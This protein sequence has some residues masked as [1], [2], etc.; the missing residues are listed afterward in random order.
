M[1]SKNARFTVLTDRVI[2]MEYSSSGKFVDDATLAFVNRNLPV[3]SFTSAT[4]GSNLV[5]KTSYLTLTYVIGTKFSSSTLNITVKNASVNTYNFGD[6]DDGNLLGTIKSL[7]NIGVTPLNCTLNA[8]LRIHDETLHC[9]WGLVSKN[10]WTTVDDS[11]NWLL[12]QTSDWWTVQ[13]TDDEDTYFFGHGD[14]FTDALYDYNLIGGKIAMPP[15]ASNGIYWSRWYNM[16][17]RDVFD[18]V[19]DYSNRGIPLD[20]YI[21][22]M[23]WHTKQGWGGYSWDKH[24]FPVPQAVMKQLQARGLL[25]SGNLHDDDG[26]RSNEEQYLPF[27]KALG[28][29]CSQNQTI[30]FQ[31]TNETHALALEDVVLKPLEDQGFGNFWWIDWQQGGAQGGCQGLKQNPTIWL[32]RLRASDH[33]RRG[34]NQRGMVLGRWGGLGNHR[35]QVGFSGDVD[36]VDWQNLAYQPYFSMTASNVLFGF[37]SHDIVSAFRGNGGNYD[38]ELYTRWVQWGA[39]SSVMRSHDRGMAAGTC[40]QS[41]PPT[42]AIDKIWNTPTPYFDAMRS[43]LQERHRLLPYLYNAQRQ[44]YDTGISLMRPLYYTFA[45]EPNAYLADQNGNYPQYMLGDDM[46]VAPIVSQGYN[47]DTLARQKLWVPPGTWID[48]LTGNVVSVGTGGDTVTRAY[49][50]SEVPRFVRA[51]AIIPKIPLQL[52][53]TVGRAQQQ[54]SSLEFVLYLAPGVNFGST[55]VYEDDASTTA[56][57]AEGFYLTAVNF[58][59]SANSMTISVSAPGGGKGYPEFPKQRNYFFRYTGSPPSSV[60]MGSTTLAYSLS[61]GPNTWRFDGKTMQVVLETAMLDTSAGFSIAITAA[62]TSFE[63]AMYGI[64]G[65]LSRANLAKQVLDTS[66]STPGAQIVQNAK[67]SDTASSGVSFSYF[68]GVDMKTFTQQVLAFQSLYQQ[69]VSEILGLQPN[70]AYPDNALVQWWNEDRQD[71]CLCSH[72]SCNQI[73]QESGYTFVRIEGYVPSSSEPSTAQLFDFYSSSAQDNLATTNPV[74]PSSY[75]PA[76]FSNGSVYASH[77]AKSGTVPLKTFYSKT[78][79]DWLTV[80]SQEGL[81][82]AKANGYVEGDIVGYVYSSSPLSL[83]SSTTPPSQD[84]WSKAYDLLTL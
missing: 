25:T 22:D 16:N 32:S 33:I 30:M 13:N 27:C 12:D 61:G 69:A 65:K 24:L 7:D 44:S 64:K 78:R 6:M 55:S 37:W 83:D 63:S 71:N 21:L 42:C 18:L 53:N 2:R 60:T 48:E 4:Q 49:D 76:I 75:T 28:I 62:D 74:M 50:L 81:D 72:A 52:G 80:A 57:T 77:L 79:Q 67:L 46:M 58:T 26:M 17:D 66:F 8:P 41:N 20:C 56:Y 45:S 51:G 19:D 23:D 84:Q 70:N 68:A 43:A 14:K 47:N 9:A 15:R 35:Y 73:Q 31:I 40:S 3:P 59:R 1:T 54:Y 10:G 82:Y 5:I 29:D 34:S 38:Y 36:V 39:F 11:D